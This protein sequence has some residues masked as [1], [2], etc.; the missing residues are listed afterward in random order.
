[1]GSDGTPDARVVVQLNDRD[2]R[3]L[4]TTHRQITRTE[5]F[6][7]RIVRLEIRRGEGAPG[8]PRTSDSNE[9]Y[10]EIAIAHLM[11][12]AIVDWA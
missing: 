4:P 11:C 5:A 6:E 7:G 2:R 9:H 1:M 10:S 12:P 3:H 8:P